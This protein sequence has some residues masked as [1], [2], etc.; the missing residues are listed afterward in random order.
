MTLTD[1][2]SLA[3]RRSLLSR[4]RDHEDRDSWQ[5]FFDRYWRLLYN[6][7]RRAGLD[8]VDA[9]DVVQDTVIAVAKEIPEFR[10]DPALGSFKAWLFRILRRRVADHFRRLGRRPAEAGITPETLE[11]TGHADAIVMRDGMSL[12]DAWDQEWERSVLDAA[13]AQVRAE[14]IPK[15]FQVFD[16]CVLKEWPVAKVASTFGMNA[17]QVYLVRHRVS[18]AVKRAARRIEGERLKGRPV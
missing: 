3:T 8:D 16:A 11:E 18:A 4:L 13:I 2:Q 10:Y 6:V 7:A 14:V 12:S 1:E 15:H 9:Q 17:A 5:T